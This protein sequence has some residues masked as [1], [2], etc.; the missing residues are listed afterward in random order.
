MCLYEV[1][2]PSPSFRSAVFFVFEYIELD[3]EI[4]IQSPVVR[5]LPEARVKSIMQQLLEGVYFM[6][7]NKVMHRDLKPSNCL[8]NRRGDVKICDFGLARSYKAGHAY[9]LPVVTL[10]YRPPEL[11]LG[12]RHYGPEIDIWSVGAI[13]GELLGRELAVDGRAEADYLQNVYKLCGAPTEAEWPEAR[14]ICPHWRA[15]CGGDAEP[16]AKALGFAAAPAAP[17][18]RRVRD[19]YGAKSPLGAGLL[20]RCLALAPAKRVTAKLALDDDYF[21]EG[22]PPLEA[23][24][25]SLPWDADLV[26][27]ARADQRRTEAAKYVA[28]KAREQA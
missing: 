1:Y 27:S 26:R 20:D 17:T 4:V 6:H 23:D 18:A 5:D 22:D 14:R 7:R 25:R 12:C 13:F 15:A 9:S 24:D 8:V 19:A 28:R 11:V 2:T 3:L 16:K 21:W 10:N